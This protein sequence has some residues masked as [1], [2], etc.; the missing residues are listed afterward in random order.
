MTKEQKDKIKKLLLEKREEV[1]GQIEQMKKDGALGKSQKEASGDLSGYSIHMADMATDNYDREMQYGYASAEQK[2]LYE[3]DAALQ[4]M[5][6][7][8]F[9]KCQTCE[10]DI[11]INRLLAMPYAKFC[12]KCQEQEDKTKQE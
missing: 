6:E 5:K 3:I 2:I 11:S 1:V 12:L 8:S 10:A 7:K 4:R 9:G